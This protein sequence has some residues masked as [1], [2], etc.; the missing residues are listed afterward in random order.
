MKTQTFT[1]RDNLKALSLFLLFLGLTLVTNSISA[2]TERI[3]TGIVSDETGP[4]EKATVLLKGTNLFTETDKTGAFTFPQKLK[5]ND[6]IIVSHLGFEDQEIKV[7]TKNKPLNVF[8]ADYSIVIVGSL[9][10]EDD[11]KSYKAKND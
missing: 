5:E 6:V 7:G 1:K 9:L 4:L 3:I 8:M 11:I 2:Q 10:T